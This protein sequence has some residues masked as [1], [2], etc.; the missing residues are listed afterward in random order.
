[1]MTNRFNR[2]RPQNAASC[3]ISWFAAEDVSQ[4]FGVVRMP[5]ILYSRD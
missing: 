1:M 2:N 3:M 4:Q 5:R